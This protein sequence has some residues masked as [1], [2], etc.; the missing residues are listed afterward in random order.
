MQPCCPRRGKQCVAGFGI[1]ASCFPIYRR[2][3]RRD[4]LHYARDILEAE[5]YHGPSRQ[6]K[7]RLVIRKAPTPA[8]RS[9]PAPQR[10][11]TR[12]LARSDTARLTGQRLHRYTWGG[13]ACGRRWGWAFTVKGCAD[14]QPDGSNL[15]PGDQVAQA[16]MPQRHAKIGKS[17]ERHRSRPHTPPLGHQSVSGVE[18]LLT[19]I[20][21][22]QGRTYRRRA[23]GIVRD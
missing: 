1:K 11:V 8:L 19:F 9:K 13:F 18:A 10:V 12:Q 16:A 22:P 21:A 14:R 15:S 7:P 23:S 2:G 5:G 17:N 3:T 4:Q 20:R 6:V